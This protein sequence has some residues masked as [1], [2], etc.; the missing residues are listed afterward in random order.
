MH[1]NLQFNSL[2]LGFGKNRLIKEVNGEF[3]SGRTN[4]IV[5]R[6]GVGKSTLLKAIAG[7]HKDFSGE[8]LYEGKLFEPQGNISLAFQDPEM[9]FFNSTVGEEVCFALL[10]RGRT[11]P[12]AEVEGKAWLQKWGLEANK[13]WNKHPLE[14]SGGEKRRVALASCT[15]F[16]PPVIML[17]EPLAGLDAFG[18][19]SLIRLLN[20][21]ARKHIV[22]VVT[23]EPEAFLGDCGKILYLR[24][25]QAEWFNSDE[26]LYEAISSTDFYPLPAWYCHEIGPFSNHRG[27]PQINSAKVLDFLERHR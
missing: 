26:F 6:A 15:S 25:N 20:E 8:I 12:Q 23:H 18:Q 1:H 27:L 21:I 14:L 22:I 16:L 13:F 10:K 24:N 4:L 11:M 19:H 9:L 2:N 17:D 7:F 3:S 5:G